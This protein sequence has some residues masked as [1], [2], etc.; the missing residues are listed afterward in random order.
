MSS[1][2]K[3]AQHFLD[4]EREFRL[5]V[6]PTEQ[7]HPQTAGLSE[8]ILRDTAAGVR[9]LQ[10]VDGDIPPAARRVFA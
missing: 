9:M 7:A 2:E 1:A 10:S 5:G 6:L 3:Q 4:N 8:A